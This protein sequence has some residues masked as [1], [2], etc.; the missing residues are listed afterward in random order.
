MPF[1]TRG[2]SAKDK[3]LSNII[4]DKDTECWIWQGA[5]QPSGYGVIRY[6][7]R[8]V[9]CHR[10]A[11][12]AFKGPLEPLKVLDHLCRNKACANPDHLESVSQIINLHRGKTRSGRFYF[13]ILCSQGLHDMTVTGRT[14]RNQ[15]RE[16]INRYQ[17]ELRAR[18][19][20]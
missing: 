16:C 15:C 3:I 7:S 10:L 4:V 2:L 5:L 9:Y 8:K 14:R 20:A 11:Y 6:Q 18:K 19:K 1:G 17:R 13:D 12:L